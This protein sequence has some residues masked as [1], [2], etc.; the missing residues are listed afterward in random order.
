MVIKSEYEKLHVHDMKKFYTGIKSFGNLTVSK[1]FLVGKNS[2]H[3]IFYQNMKNNK[4][5]LAS[6]LIIHGYGEY[7]GR[8]ICPAISFAS[9]DL[10]VHLFDFSG[11][12]HSSGKRFM[13]SYEDLQHDFHLVIS[14]IRNDLPLFV[15]CHSMGGGLMLTY[16]LKNPDIKIA[17]VIFYSPW[18]GFPKE[19]NLNEFAQYCLRWVPKLFDVI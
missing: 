12:G 5:G 19:L 2:H 18:V 6:L 3:K 8:Y 16:L 9:A 10:D 17:G 11:F 15:F 7:S 14:K 4:P 1:E 13:A